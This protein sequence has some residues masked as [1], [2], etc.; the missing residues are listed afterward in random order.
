[1]TTPKFEEQLVKTDEDWT[2]TRPFILFKDPPN[3]NYLNTSSM[4]ILRAGNIN[5]L[6]TLTEKP[7]EVVT[8]MYYY[9]FSRL[10]YC[11]KGKRF[12]PREIHTRTLL[13]VKQLLK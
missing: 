3:L 11:Y 9:C 2:V 13:E 7:R 8:E 12:N 10:C 5:F 4:T 6:C 1:M